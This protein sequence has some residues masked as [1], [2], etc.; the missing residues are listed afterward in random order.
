MLDWFSESMGDEK[1][2]WRKAGMGNVVGA[3]IRALE[4]G[5][6]RNIILTTLILLGKRSA[7]GTRGF[8]EIYPPADIGFS[9]R[10]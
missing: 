4:V 2:G 1:E 8:M 9:R 10:L 7:I 3:V 5:F 6:L